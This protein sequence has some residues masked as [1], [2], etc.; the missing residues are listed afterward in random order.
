MKKVLLFAN[1]ESIHTKKWCEGWNLIGYE[2]VVSGISGRKYDNKLTFHGRIDPEGGNGIIYLKNILKFKK[3]LNNSGSNNINAHYMTSYGLISALLK[4]KGDFLILSLHGTDVLVN[5]NKNPVYLQMA[6]FIFNKADLI[7]SVSRPMT[8]KILR[9]FP[10]LNRKVI[11]QQYGVNIRNLGEV[12]HNEKVINIV[13]NRQWKINSNYPV[14][15][16]SL[17]EY[18][19]LNIRFI[20]YDDSDY[21]KRMKI[22]YPEFEKDM[23]SLVPYEKN[24]EMISKS[25]IFISIPTSDGTPLSVIE[26][27]YLGCIPIVSDI[28]SNKELISD[29]VNGF[30]SKISS[31]DLIKNIEKALNLSEEKRNKMIER[32]RKIILERFDFERNFQKIKEILDRRNDLNGK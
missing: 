22:G 12:R 10:D 29:G 31:E 6:G 28:I 15:F 5:M 27:M 24:I 13:T 4:R 14:I 26:A 2:P 7:V 16:E 3:A 23:V 19:N 25:E 18:K 32:N 30:L 20:G 21:A 17:K 11:T 9:Y 1:P 8:E